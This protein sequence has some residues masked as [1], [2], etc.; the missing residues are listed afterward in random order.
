MHFRYVDARSIQSFLD[1]ISSLMIRSRDAERNS[2][3]GGAY[4]GIGIKNAE[5]K[6]MQER[7]AYAELIDILGRCVASNYLEKRTIG[8]QSEEYIVFYINRWLCVH[9]GLPLSYGGWKPLSAMQARD[10]C[11]SS[12]G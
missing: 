9:Y 11:N 10:M 6:W 2:Y 3:A 12:A 5:I 1:N 8:H 7:E 4:T